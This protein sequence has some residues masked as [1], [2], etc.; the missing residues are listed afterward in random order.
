MK[1]IYLCSTLKSDWNRK[2]NAKLCKKLERARIKCYLPQRDTR[3]TD[4]S[5]GIWRQN[6]T[7][8]RSS[9]VLLAVA[10]NASVNWGVEV[11]YAYGIKKPIIALTESLEEIPVMASCMITE[12]FFLKRRLYDF[13]FYLNTLVD[14]LKQRVGRAS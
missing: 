10:K 5:A 9:A 8:I 2:F 14:A 6:T 12:Y 4:P 11:G 13:D 7:A 1:A 3:Q